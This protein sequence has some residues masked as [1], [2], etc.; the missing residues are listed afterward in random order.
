MRTAKHA[1]Y[2]R[3][4]TDRRGAVAV[5]AALL[6]IV[7]LGLVAFA[8]DLGY[9]LST[10]QELQ[11]TADAAAL[12]ACWEYGQK[13]SQGCTTSDAVASGRSVAAQ[14]ASANPVANVNPAINQNS[15]NSSTGDLVFGTIS[16]FYAPQ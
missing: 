3:R 6:T 13:L 5:L 12:A 16:N 4:P 14:Y 8:V 11:R 9:I 10:K 1:G 7:M 2:R 15:G